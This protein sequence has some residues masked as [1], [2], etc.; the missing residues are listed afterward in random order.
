MCAYIA[1]ILAYVCMY[2][3]TYRNI[4]SMLKSYDPCINWED[5][6]TILLTKG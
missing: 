4:S 6:T 5:A 1:K 3:Y 2:I